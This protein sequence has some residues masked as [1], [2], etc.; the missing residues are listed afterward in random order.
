M[1]L[2]FFLKHTLTKDEQAQFTPLLTLTEAQL[3]ELEKSITMVTQ[4]HPKLVGTW[5]IEYHQKEPK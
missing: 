4:A 5:T 1:L 3:S 2:L